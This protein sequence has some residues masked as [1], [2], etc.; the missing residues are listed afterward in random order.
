MTNFR[1]ARHAYARRQLSDEF[2]KP[3]S[4]RPGRIEGTCE[5]VTPRTPYIA[6]Y[7]LTVAR[8]K[9]GK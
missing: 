9:L 7:T 8:V 5:L 2:H 1:S 3:E 6:V 4:G